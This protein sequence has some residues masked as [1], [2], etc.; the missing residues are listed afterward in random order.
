MDMI[1]AVASA[2][3]KEAQLHNRV[4]AKIMTSK[5]SAQLS[6]IKNHSLSIL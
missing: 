5:S 2:L 4:L 3:G 1:I 6:G